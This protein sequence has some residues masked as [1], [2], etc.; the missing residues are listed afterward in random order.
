MGP[1]GIAVL[2]GMWWDCGIGRS[3]A[4]LRYWSGCGWDGGFCP[5]VARL[6]YLS[7]CGGFAVLIGVWWD[8]GICQSEIVVGS[9]AA[10]RSEEQHG[11]GGARPGP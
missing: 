7:G 5:G 10:V 4:G 11:V 1:S 8:C 2:I 3:V 9:P 6:C